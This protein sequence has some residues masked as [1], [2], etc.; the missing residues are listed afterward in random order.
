MR[1]VQE[2]VVRETRTLR[3][4][5]RELETELRM[6]LLGHEAGNPGYGQGL[7]LS[8]YRASS[9]PYHGL[10]PFAKALE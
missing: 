2:R 6:S 4:T 9:H 5:W 1:S 3:V 10:R 7:V 8:G